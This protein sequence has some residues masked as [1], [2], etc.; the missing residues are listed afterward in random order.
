MKDTFLRSCEHWSEASRDEME[1]FY[2]LA[3][4]DYKFLASAFNWKEW[5]ETHQSNVGQRSLKLL[6]VACG[7]GK[8]PSALFQYAKIRD[9]KILP[10]S[11]PAARNR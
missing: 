11:L 4:I 3:S 7:S 1:Y 9:A 2:S 8:F 5:F 10:G 6:D